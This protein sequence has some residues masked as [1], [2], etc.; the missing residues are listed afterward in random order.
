MP[1]DNHTCSDH[2]R[3]D[4]SQFIRLNSNNRGAIWTGSL[5]MF[6]SSLK[7]RLKAMQRQTLSTMLCTT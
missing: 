5:K 4:R 6:E 7:K 2:F 1:P 3:G